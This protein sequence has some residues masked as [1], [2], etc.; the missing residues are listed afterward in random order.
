MGD[1]SSV[2]ESA[3]V[4]NTVSWISLAYIFMRKINS[5]RKK[6]KCPKFKKRINKMS[7]FLHYKIL[8]KCEKGLLCSSCLSAGYN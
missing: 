3:S 7:L 2:I 5:I 8:K 6:T 4:S 1:I